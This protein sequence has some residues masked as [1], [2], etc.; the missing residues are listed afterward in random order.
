M[1]ALMLH[2]ENAENVTIP[3]GYSNVSILGNKNLQ[4]IETTGTHEISK[5]TIQDAENLQSVNIRKESFT[6]P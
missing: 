2:T 5:I 3:D 4:R 6:V 1:D